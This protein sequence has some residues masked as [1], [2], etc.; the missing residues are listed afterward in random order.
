M[1]LSRVETWDWGWGGLLIFTILLFFRP[2]DQIP[3]LGN[4]HISDVA[5]FIGLTAMVFLNLSRGLPITRVTPELAVISFV[6]AALLGLLAAVIPARS[7]A[8][9][10][11]VGA[12]RHVG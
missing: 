6:L 12:L 8:K 5:A 7:A 3:G 1:R 9:L 4:S 2:Q 10:D 11:V